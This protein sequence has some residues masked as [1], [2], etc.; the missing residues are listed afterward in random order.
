ME[1]SLPTLLVT[2]LAL[3]VVAAIIV[4]ALGSANR[5]AVRVVALAAVVANLFLTAAVV[6]QSM[7]ELRARA[8]QISEFA[9]D[10]RIRTF[11]PMGVP[12][13]ESNSATTRYRLL[14][15]PWSSPGSPTPAISFFLGI[16]GLNIW[17]IALTN[18]LM[19][20]SVLISWN[21]IRERA[22]EFYAWLLVL[23]TGMLGV[24]LAFDVVLFYVFFELTLVPLFFVI[25]I[26]GGPARRE[27][28]RKFFLF[29]LAGSLIT[30]LGIIGL[31]LAVR[32]RTGELTFS[33]PRLVELMQMQLRLPDADSI[34]YWRQVQVWCFL[35]MAVGFA[36]KVPLFPVH[37][38]LPL[39]HVEA[40]TAG[41][42]LLAGVL[43]K[44]GTYAF[45]RLCLPLVPDAVVSV[46]VPLIGTLA[47]IG[48][49][50]GSLCA[51]AQRDI[52]KLVA[53]SSVA[54][55]GFCML[56]VFALN[57][58]GLTGGLMQMINH[59]LSTG[60]LFL[61]V[62]MLYDRYH[63]RMMDDYS[64]MA[65]RLKLL[66]IAMMIIC[67]SSVGMP[68]LNGFIGEML[69]LAGVI[70]MPIG[71]GAFVLAAVG[72]AGIVLGAW[73]LFTML[74]SVFFG[75]LRQPHHDPNE[76]P[77]EDLNLRELAAIVPVIAACMY[78]G[79]YPQP[80]ISTTQRDVA[81]V[82]DIVQKRQSQLMKVEKPELAGQP[83]IPLR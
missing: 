29:T 56:G 40:P 5:S 39:A 63:T 9:E 34:E 17:L 75:P 36:V 21:S 18:F 65:A 54:H 62:G 70:D 38:W 78:I 80:M 55:L 33:I 69:V 28:A 3:P 26:W 72:A 45:L 49:I 1:E 27:A 11:E 73:Y 31:L 71:A 24:F 59:G 58:V 67:L 83:E 2:I 19:L 82:A 42:V 66:A 41:S 6:K 15:I 68:F 23:Q 81:L 35:A 46:G 64:G 61:L 44:L 32:Y 79:V 77:V 51:F 22:N 50:Y 60:G 20:P 37:T 12:G 16:D 76:G 7:P 52:K 47:A 25:G 53:Y 57:A 43:L 10:D 4:A 8:L 30:L 13:A 74:R 14:E 48:V